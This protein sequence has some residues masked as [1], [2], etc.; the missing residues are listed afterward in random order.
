MLTVDDWIDAVAKRG[1]KPFY[2]H[3][4]K[5]QSDVYRH[6]A[7]MWSTYELRETPDGEPEMRGI[8]SIQ[9]VN[10]GTRWRVVEI[11]WQVESPAL[12]IPEKYLS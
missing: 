8:N 7:H 9:A 10:D 5:V 11:V 6:L 1:D 2:E 3:Q 12:P 4:V